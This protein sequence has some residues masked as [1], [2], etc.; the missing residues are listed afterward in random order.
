[1]VRKSAQIECKY[2]IASNTGKLMLLN[3]IKLKELLFNR[4][5]LLAIGS[6]LTQLHAPQSWAKSI[7][8]FGIY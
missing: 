7:M 5:A 4:V 3:F 8:H 2:E 6:R 1:M